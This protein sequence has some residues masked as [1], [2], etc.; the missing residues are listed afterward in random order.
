MKKYELCLNDK[1]TFLDR[2]LFRIKS[3]ISFTTSN[4]EEISEGDLGGY[5]EKEENLSQDGNAWVGGNAE[6][7][8]DAWV[9]GNAEVCGNAWVYGDAKVYGNACV[10]G[11][12]WVYGDAKVYGNA[13]VDGNAKVYGDAKVYGNACVD[14]NAEVGGNAHIFTASPIGRYA[15]T[16]TFFRT[17]NNEIA[18]GFDFNF[19]TIQE[20]EQIMTDWSENQ[21]KVAKA[22]IEA[23]KLH[24]DLDE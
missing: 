17:K 11:N 2:E 3:L 10:D 23:A 15:Q 18:I 9:G 24:I 5:I 7:Y 14:G 4:G 21:V 12:A 19:Y 1:I 6:V 22:V 8:G 16:I 20:F 13:C